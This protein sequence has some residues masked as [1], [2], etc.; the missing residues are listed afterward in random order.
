MVIGNRTYCGNTFTTYTKV[1]WLYCL[2]KSNTTL[3][4]SYSSV[5]KKGKQANVPIQVEIS[6]R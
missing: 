6:L 1:Q 2:S 5:K 4:V 3:Y